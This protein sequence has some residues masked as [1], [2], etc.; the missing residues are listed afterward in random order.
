MGRRI[1]L[2]HVWPTLQRAHLSRSAPRSPP[3]ARLVAHSAV[4][5]ALTPGLP[6]IEHVT[7]QP[8]GGHM[9]QILF[10]PQEFG[11]VRPGP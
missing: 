11:K 6:R 5:F 9:A 7:I 8:R 3:P 2:L 10:V 1:C 4:A